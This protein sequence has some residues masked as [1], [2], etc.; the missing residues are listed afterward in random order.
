MTIQKEILTLTKTLMKMKTISSDQEANKKAI[1][2]IVSYFK[3]SHVYIKRYEKNGVHSLVISH[4]P[5]DLT[6]D[7]ILQSHV[8][9]VPATEEEFIPQE[10]NNCLYGRGSN[11]TKGAL[12]ALI[13]L[14]KYLPTMKI[15]NHV[16]LMITSDEELAGYNGAK[17]L[18]EDVGYRSKFF[19][20]GEG[21]KEHF[22]IHTESKGIIGMKILSHGIAAHGARTWQGENAVEKLFGVYTEIKK[23]FP[24][25]RENLE[26]YS[27]I[28]LAKLHG[29][30]AINSVP[31]YAEAILDIRFTKEWNTGD[32]IIEKI[33]DIIGKSNRVEIQVNFHEPYIY[34]DTKNH[35]VK[36]LGKILKKH[37][38]EVTH[39]YSQVHASNDARFASML[40]IPV[41]EFGPVGNH[42]HN[43]NEYIEIPSLYAFYDMMKEL[44]E[45]A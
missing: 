41:V 25:K 17:Y 37:V 40:G 16:G 11:D 7:I 44:V 6:F 39:V 27:T 15:K 2:Y 43:K 29:G 38:P 9:V 31:Y 1:D 45:A 18:M 35:Y 5:F 33:K 12:A 42:N 24:H 36:V 30:E 22:T 14:M 4:K 10:K 21:L 3:G 28:N 13:V 26:W 34:T 8:D 23:I 20:T 32:E 19:L